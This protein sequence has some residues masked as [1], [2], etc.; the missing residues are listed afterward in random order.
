VRE[1]AESGKK[2]I[3]M[4]YLPIIA[5]L[6]VGAN[7]AFTQEGR[8]NLGILTCTSEDK[9]TLSRGFKPTG[10]GAEERYVGTVRIGNEGVLAAKTVLIWAVTGPADVKAS[11]G[12]LAQRFVMGS[13]PANQPATL[14]GEKISSITLQFETNNGTQA[15]AI[16]HV[17]LKL[18]TTPA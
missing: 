3:A 2:A 5:I 9:G 7:P 16:T 8:K 11:S 10:G 12:L 17:D 15:A 1:C 6:L 13:N 14:I 18:A 4:R